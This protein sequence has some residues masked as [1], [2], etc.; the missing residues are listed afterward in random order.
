MD[1]F[2]RTAFRRV[3]SLAYLLTRSYRRAASKSGLSLDHLGIPTKPFNPSAQ[4]IVHTV[5]FMSD[6]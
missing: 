1:R 5:D 6:P 2:G 3:E 4:P